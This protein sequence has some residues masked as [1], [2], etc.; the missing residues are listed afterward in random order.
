MID[1]CFKISFGNFE[2]SS[3]EFK[4]FV[5]SFPLRNVI[6]EHKDKK[7]NLLD[8][9]YIKEVMEMKQTRQFVRIHIQREKLSSAY[10]FLVSSITECGNKSK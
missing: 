6:T 4:L 1:I 2:I 10:R 7:I 8:N 9:A 5:S 3:F